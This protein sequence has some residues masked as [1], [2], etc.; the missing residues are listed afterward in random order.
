[1]ATE[2]RLPREGSTTMTSGVVLEWRAEV[3]EEVSAGDPLVE[4]EADKV[5]FEVEA[6]VDGV[7]LERCAEPGEE[8]DVG[9]VLAR[10]GSAGE[11]LAPRPTPPEDAAAADADS[12]V[13][14]APPSAP[15]G[16][17]A[18][19]PRHYRLPGRTAASPGA[20]RRARELR[21]DLTAV[22]GSG[23]DG[24]VQRADIELARPTSPLAGLSGPRRVIA[25]RMA[26]ASAGT[27]A[28]TLTARADVTALRESAGRGWSL[29]D[30]VV[31]ATVQLLVAHPDL[32]ASLTLE[33]I[34]RH[35]HVAI[36]YAVH[37]PS[38]LVVPVIGEAHHLTLDELATIR[39]ELIGRALEGA[40]RPRDIDG[41]TFT[42]TNLGP[43]GVDMFTPVITPGQAAVLG[44]GKTSAEFVPPAGDPQV[45]TQMW[46]S[47]TFDH[48]IVD[49]A[50]AARF[51]QALVRRLAE[52]GAA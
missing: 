46:L 3:G 35:D 1:M 12:A 20:R 2:V 41:G 23:P 28:V 38:G 14:P 6:P 50:P 45:R 33:G 15:A 32:N 10:I 25:E 29:P 40:L 42:V 34:V 52:G 4:I 36:G 24:R 9:G 17:G 18:S 16:A 19:G 7:L 44:L 47:L 5:S 48:R 22:T 39:R 37:A 13:T 27:A 30:A 21:V 11:E 31:H 8:I 43:L 51:L 26:Q 49:G